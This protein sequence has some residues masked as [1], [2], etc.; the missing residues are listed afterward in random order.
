MTLKQIWRTLQQ[1][2]LFVRLAGCAGCWFLQDLTYYGNLLFQT[3]FLEKIFHEESE[4]HLTAQELIVA[5]IALPG[6]L[7]AVLLMKPLGP[8]VIQMQGFLVSGLLFVG[9]AKYYT[10][11]DGLSRPFTVGLYSM[12]FF[13]SNFGPKCTTFILPSQVYR[14]AFALPSG[15]SKLSSFSAPYHHPAL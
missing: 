7:V 12:T 10:S 11:F 1:P 4:L 13:F 15:L 8:K 9:L 2:G 5:L 3:A 6:Y 14:P